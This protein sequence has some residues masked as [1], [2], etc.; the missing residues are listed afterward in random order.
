MFPKNGAIGAS[1]VTVKDLGTIFATVNSRGGS[2]EVFGYYLPYCDWSPEVEVCQSF[3][4]TG[5]PSW[6][7][8]VLDSLDDLLLGVPYKVLPNA[9]NYSDEWT[10]ITQMQLRY[11]KNHFSAGN[12]TLQFIHLNIPHLPAYVAAEYFHKARP[13]DAK[14]NYLLNLAFSDYVLGQLMTKVEVAARRINILFVVSSDHG[15]RFRDEVMPEGDL[16]KQ[17]VPFILWQRGYRE[18]RVITAMFNTIITR[19]VIEAYLDGSIN[20]LEDIASFIGSNG[21]KQ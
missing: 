19:R 2:S 1:G 10:E 7:E 15:F 20:T 16:R 5:L 14:G 6:R 11:L 17:H 3:S 21:S 8:V 4:L 12:A 18:G 9:N 13:T